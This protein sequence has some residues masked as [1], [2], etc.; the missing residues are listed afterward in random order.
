[1]DTQVIELLGR[2]RLAD[3]LLMAGLEVAYPAQDRGVDVIAYVDL[4]ERA[5]RFVACPIQMKAASGR[6]FGVYQKYQKFS[7]IVLAFVWNL[8]SPDEAETFALT[9]PEAVRVAEEMGWTQTASWIKKGGY[10]SKPS[11]RL[12]EL[13]EPHRMTPERWYEKVMALTHRAV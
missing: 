3:E 9:Y 1:M 8:R 10:S 11:V 12:M 2:H 5:E 7:D 13:M 6:R 4:D